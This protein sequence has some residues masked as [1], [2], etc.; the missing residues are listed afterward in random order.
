[1]MDAENIYPHGHHPSLPR[2]DLHVQCPAEV[3]RRRDVASGEVLF[4]RLRGRIPL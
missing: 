4:H 3:I 1:M 2:F